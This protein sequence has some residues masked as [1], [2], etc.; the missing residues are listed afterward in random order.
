MKHTTIARRIPRRLLTVF[1]ATLLFA[2][3]AARAAECPESSP[4][5]PQE[6]RRLAKE[7]FATA[8]TAENTGDDKEAT[9]AYACSYKMVA[10]PYTAYNLARVAERSGETELAL[11]MYKAYVAL[12]PDATDQDVV[13]EKIKVLEEK[14]AAADTAGAPSETGLPET[15]PSETGMEPTET[16]ATE[17]TPPEPPADELTPP[18][19]PKP[20]EVVERP[21]EPEEG[22]PSHTWEWVV[23]GVTVAALVGGIVTNLVA[24]AKMDTCRTDAN[25]GLLAT[26]NDECNAARP[27][28]YTSYALFSVAAAGAALDTVLIILNRRG[29]ESAGGEEEYSFGPLL[30]PNGGGLTARGRF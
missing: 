15:G 6:R 11:K 24:R 18:P 12:K 3:A 14:M 4:E 20:A 16:T 2:P 10:H 19:Q 28:A 9:R 1:F 27:M 5:D 17:T 30:F 23:G 8:E 7:W 29:G 21:I 26:A 13:K 22:P 25:N